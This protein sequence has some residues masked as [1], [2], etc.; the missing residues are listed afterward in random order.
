MRGP[1]D[2]ISENAQP[3]ALVCLTGALLIGSWWM[4]VVGGIIGGVKSR[5]STS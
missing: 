2:W 3:A 4:V 5:L 1:F